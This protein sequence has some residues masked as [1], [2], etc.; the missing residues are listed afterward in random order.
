MSFSNKLGDFIKNILPAPFTIAVLLT[1]ITFVL[2]Y[3]LSSGSEGS[4]HF[5]KILQYWEKGLWDNQLMVFAM[6]MML[7]LVLGHC[8]ALSTPVEKIINKVTC[9]L[10]TSDAADE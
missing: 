10:Y 3:N 5:F 4:S 6:Q 9:L 2:A 7:M 8:L 1:F